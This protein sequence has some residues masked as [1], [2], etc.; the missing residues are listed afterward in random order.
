MSLVDKVDNMKELYKYITF[1]AEGHHH[2]RSY[3]SLSSIECMVNCK[4]LRLRTGE[5]WNDKIDRNNL[6][7]SRYD[8][9]SFAKCFSFSQ[10]EN[11]AMWMLYAGNPSGGAMVDITCLKKIKEELKK[12]K[13]V[14]KQG[15][16]YVLNVDG[17][18][19]TC[20]L[21]DIIYIGEKDSGEIQLKRSEEKIVINEEKRK[22]ID[23]S[24]VSR[25]V[26]TWP[27][28][29]ENECRLIV[30]IKKS[31]LGNR[32]YSEFEAVDINIEKY[33]NEIKKRIYHAP[34]YELKKR[35]YL[36]SKLAGQIEWNLCSSWSCK[37]ACKSQQ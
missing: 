4:T 23:F 13:V 32:E 6:N 36:L 18:D 33:I 21:V 24:D 1:T 19:V 37:H 11:V 2:Y 22:E 25:Y 16:T 31:L 29:Y 5:D 7:S 20:N 3:T 10:R 35:K 12:I 26:K 14:D 15:N 28:R 8:Y 9:I 27:W 34:T 30:T 17:K